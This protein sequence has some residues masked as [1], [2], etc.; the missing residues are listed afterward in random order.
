MDV[1]S[2]D[3]FTNVLARGRDIDDLVEAIRDSWSYSLED[4]RPG[5]AIL[6]D[7]RVKATDLDLACLLST[8]AKRKAVVILPKY[9][10]ATRKKAGGASGGTGGT[11]T[12]TLISPENRR[13]QLIRLSSN[14]DYFSFSALVIDQNV[15]DTANGGSLG[16]PRYFH[17]LGKDGRWHPGWDSIQFVA[18]AKENDFIK[19][20][21]LAVGA[22]MAFKQFVNP[23]R[24]TAFYSPHYL[25]TKLA[26]TRLE[27]EVKTLRARIKTLK[28]ATSKPDGVG[29]S[30]SMGVGSAKPERDSEESKVKFPTKNVEVPIFEA[31]I[32][33]TFNGKE[34][35]PGNYTG[36]DSLNAMLSRITNEQL[37]ELRFATRVTE[38][39]FYKAK[40]EKA[41]I[42]G[43]AV[44]SNRI[45]MWGDEVIK[46]TSWRALNSARMTMETGCSLR[47][48]IRSKTIEVDDK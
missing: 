10:S 5:P 8:L 6:H 7:G 1:T 17:I 35:Q 40:G 37:P 22:E 3:S 9:M 45:T 32:D 47:Y 24:W 44:E 39:A 23:D 48:R 30:T 4:R 38:L 33:A 19:Q 25:I 34:R 27:E 43:F 42:P 36:L 26:I 2:K 31:E 41:G 21:G 18:D 14:Q 29:T 11:S 15:L 13:G 28:D 16:A 12:Q 46:R 20:Y